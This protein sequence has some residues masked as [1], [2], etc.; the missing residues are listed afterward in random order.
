MRINFFIK[1]KIFLLTILFCINIFA[2]ADAVKSFDI[3][4]FDKIATSGNWQLKITSGKEFTVKILNAPS[5]SNAIAVQKEKDIL[6]LWQQPNL[7]FH[8]ESK[9]MAEV[10][11]P[12]LT[13]LKTDGFS[14]ITLNNF[15]ADNFLLNV[16]GS[17]K[18]TGNNNSFKN[19]TITSS[20]TALSDFTD[21]KITNANIQLYGRS[22]LNIKI[23]NGNLLGNIYGAAEVNYSGNP[24][25]ISV[26]TFG[27]A[28]IKPQ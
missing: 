9:I 8:N 14:D 25:N 23:T 21:N 16:N 28:E 10:T 24:K 11:L 20:G 5:S 4:N 12:T 3:T 2:S 26:G 19:L 13:I 1:T 22:K 15:L 6:V 18:I 17:G 27:M 7:W